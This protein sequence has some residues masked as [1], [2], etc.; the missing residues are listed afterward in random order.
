MF[1]QLD[2]ILLLQSCRVSVDN[3]RDNKLPVKSYEPLTQL[4]LGTLSQNMEVMD[5]HPSIGRKELVQQTQFSIL[6]LYQDE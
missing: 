1:V 4:I 3:G 5:P 2:Q 6:N